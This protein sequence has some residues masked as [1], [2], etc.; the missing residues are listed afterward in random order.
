VTRFAVRGS[1]ADYDGWEAI[2]N[3]G[4]GFGDVLPYFNRLETDADFGDQPWHGNDGPILVDR[5]L[6][7]EPTEVGAAALNAMEGV[8]FPLVVDHNQPGAV[9]AGPMP[10]SSR[11][12]LRVTTADAYLPLGHTPQNLTIRPDSQVACLVFDGIRASGVRLV[13]GSTVQAGWIA[14]SAGT[15]G[16]PPILMR[17]GIGPAEHLRSVGVPVRVN[18]P[19]VG[20]NLADHPAVD[21]EPDYRGPP[22]KVRSCIR[23]P[24]STARQPRATRHRT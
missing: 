11:G 3:T 23:L 7:L 1:P 5:Y 14:L 18:L 24:P 12:G 19:G 10:M 8:G 21:L 4:W 20:E 17:S 2:G 15:Y 16:S 9:G 13:D 6:D 22:G